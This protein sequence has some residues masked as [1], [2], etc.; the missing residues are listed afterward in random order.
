MDE[1]TQ[2]AVYRAQSKNAEDSRFLDVPFLLFEEQEAGGAIRRHLHGL[3]TKGSKLKRRE[4]TIPLHAN[5]PPTCSLISP[6]PL[7]PEFESV[8]SLLW[9]VF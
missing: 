5:P 3:G 8:R 1:E 9:Y 2:Y 7:C 6:V 4:A